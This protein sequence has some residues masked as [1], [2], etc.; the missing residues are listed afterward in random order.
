MG[1]NAQRFFF[2][3]FIDIPHLDKT[4]SLGVFEVAEFE[5]L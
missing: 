4:L 2:G 3:Y 5:P 1:E